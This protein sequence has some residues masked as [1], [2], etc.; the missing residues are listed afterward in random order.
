VNTDRLCVRVPGVLL[1]AAE[2]WLRAG[3]YRSVSTGIA[4]FAD[5][6]LTM[7]TVAGLGSRGLSITGVRS[8]GRN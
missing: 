6:S 3:M 7:I 2:L 5:G 1:C 8:P 4:A